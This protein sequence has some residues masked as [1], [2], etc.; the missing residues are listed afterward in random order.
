[1]GE[2]HR[3]VKRR[4]PGVIAHT[5][6]DP[7]DSRRLGLFDCQFGGAAHHQMA[8][9]V[10]AV[11]QRSRSAL[12]DDA[13]VWLGIDAAGTQTANVKRQPDH[14]MGVAAAQIRFNHKVTENLRVGFRQA[15]SD[16][17]AGHKAGEIGSGYA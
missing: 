16:K 17:G 2:R 8:H 12:A 11:D 14:A 9:A 4:R 15:G 6:A 3:H 10:V 1:V 7:A 13:D 5:R